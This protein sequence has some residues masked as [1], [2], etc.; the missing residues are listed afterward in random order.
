MIG[1]ILGDRYTIVEKVGEGGMA[2]VYKA[3]CSLLN[4]YVAIKV[5]RKEFIND[6]EF[7]EKFKRE[8]QAAASLSHANIVNVYDVGM[9]DDIYYIVMEYLDGKTLKDIIKEK[10]KIDTEETLDISMKVVDALNHAHAN[11]VIHR[12]IKPH[13][14]MVTSDG[15][16]KV[17]DFGIARA[18]TSSTIT[19]TNSVMGSAHYF[20][21]EQARGGYTDEKSDIY[22]VGIM[23]YEMITGKL[24]FTG[25]SPVAIAI[26]HI[27]EEVV[28]PSEIEPTVSKD[29]EKVIMKCI[30]KNQSDRYKDTE[31]LLKDLRSI[32][33]GKGLNSDNLENSYTQVLPPVDDTVLMSETQRIPIIDEEV[34]TPKV[35]KEPKPRIK[36]EK[37][38]KEKK[39]KNKLI[40]GGAILLALF[41]VLLGT[42]LALSLRGIS[43]EADIL[44]P[45][46]V[47]KSEADAKT[48]LENL[49]LRLNVVGY[50]E[51]EQEKD[52]IIEQIDKAGTKVKK[53]FA[54]KV[55]VSSEKVTEL[56]LLPNFVG[57]NIDD[58]EKVLREKGFKVGKVQYEENEGEQNTV[59]SQSIEPGSQLEPGTK[60]DLIVSKG[61]SVKT[62]TAPNLIGMFQS[63][64]GGILAEN[65]LQMGKVSTGSSS[66]PRG[67]IL[68]QSPA[69]GTSVEEGTSI[70]LIVSDG[71][72]GNGKKD[73]DTNDDNNNNNNDDNDDEDG[74]NNKRVI[75]EDIKIPQT[76]KDS[77]QIKVIKDQDGRSSVIYDSSHD[78]SE[79]EITLK[80]KGQKGNARLRIYMDEQPYDQR[81]I[82]F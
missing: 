10:G 7:I 58:A 23:M 60:V 12:D 50:R 27:Q 65:K 70:E 71:A 44:I 64:V 59:V 46:L 74:E 29:L 48:E 9:Q 3:K 4:R 25:D 18:A 37:P 66:E 15:R 38:K 78:V 43:S 6:E 13:N 76:G 42:G 24:P 17:T 56:S 80:I 35:A 53:G 1:K 57:M 51:G 21:P 55:I 73:E 32:K 81:N 79:Q 8:A 52:H 69:P 62:V 67:K 26:K 36:K 40:A 5:L 45:E 49:K 34:A 61:R 77:V 2:I 31:E 16:V 20:S 19:S 28:P 41:V 33:S 14:I 39:K 11:K 75:Y 22:S 68:S 54:V 30:E 82:S 63:N 47:G 72:G